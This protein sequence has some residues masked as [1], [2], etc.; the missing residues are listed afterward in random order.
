MYRIIGGDGREY[1]P[2]SLE[3]LAQWIHE[4]RA[5]AQTQ[6]RSEDSV[7]W[8]ALGQVPEVAALLTA[9]ALAAPPPFAAT[10]APG[11]HYEGDYELDI[12]GCVSRAW[13]VLQANFWPMVGGCAIYLLIVGGLSGFAQIPFIGLLFSLASLIVTGPL[14]GGVYGFLLRFLR[15]QPA[16]IAEIFA[17]FRDRLGQFI[18]GYLVPL[19]LSMAFALPGAA[20]VAVPTII[21]VSR[22]QPH[23]GLIA[24]AAFGFL[25]A[26]IPL[27]YLS[28]CWVYTL[29]LVMDRRMDFWEAMK[30]SRAQVRRH[31]WATLGLFLVIGLINLAGMALCCVGVFVS[32][33]LTFTALL[34]AYEKALLPRQ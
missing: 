26:M 25:L 20:L 30:A 9:P 29:P 8:R 16:E 27:I 31:W 17:G 28:V 2:V 7:E 19:F 34:A 13:G 33:P 21:M 14:L 5:N 4:G 10:I 32:V 23:A 1:G 11:P 15:G 6:V 18:L 3:Q 12:G 24:L 22:E